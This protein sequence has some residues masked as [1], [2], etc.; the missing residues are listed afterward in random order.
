M[1][2]VSFMVNDRQADCHLQSCRAGGIKRCEI[3]ILLT[4]IP[5]ICASVI[6][7]MYQVKNELFLI[8]LSNAFKN[9]TTHNY[10]CHLRHA[11]LMMREKT[12]H[13][14]YLINIKLF[15]NTL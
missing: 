3:R 9:V 6:L 15:L 8:P 12:L 14:L 13:K 11:V 2:S 10:I 4:G 5:E 1:F 7:M